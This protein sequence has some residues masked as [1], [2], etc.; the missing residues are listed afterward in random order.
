[1][2]S[3]KNNRIVLIHRLVDV[4]EAN[5][6]TKTIVESELIGKIRKGNEMSEIR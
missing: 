3:D 6:S 2:G 1:M 5:Y 4:Y